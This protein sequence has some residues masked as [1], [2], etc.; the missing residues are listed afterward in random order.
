MLTN[1]QASNT[2]FS[3]SGKT[4]WGINNEGF[5]V[6]RKLDINNGIHTKHT[7]KKLYSQIE[8]PKTVAYHSLQ[9]QNTFQSMHHLPSPIIKTLVTQDYQYI[10]VVFTASQLRVYSLKAIRQAHKRKDQNKIR[11]SGMLDDFNQK[12]L[13]EIYRA[14]CKENVIELTKFHQTNRVNGTTESVETTI[15]LT[16]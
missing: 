7:T 16:L 9:G 3:Q 12:S 6:A 14:E 15:K 4:L 13:G 2:W 5:L 1:T 10:V 8:L 11:S